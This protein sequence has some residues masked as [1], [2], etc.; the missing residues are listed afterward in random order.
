MA[1]WASAMAR[2]MARPSPCPPEALERLEQ[3]VHVAGRDHGTAVADADPDLPGRHG[4]RH[5]GPAAG[6]VVAQRVV[7]Q[8][9]HQGFDQARVARGGRRGQRGLDPDAQAP[10]LGAALLGDLAGQL[11]QVER[12][13]L[14]HA[15]LAAG[16]GQQRFD[17]AFLLVAHDQ[18]VP[19]GR[20]ER[21]GGS[22]GIGQRHLQQGPLG[23]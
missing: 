10:G 13:P 14:L 20:A 9:G 23:G 15:A 3:P 12:L 6:P 5:L 22:A 21:L 4:G 2:T 18:G 1:P 19:A 17:Q 11:G 8:V 16:Q 7:D